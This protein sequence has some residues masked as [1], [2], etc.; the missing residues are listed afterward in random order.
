MLTNARRRAPSWKLGRTLK[1]GKKGRN[2]EGIPTNKRM[3]RDAHD[4]SGYPKGQFDKCG[5]S[6]WMVRM[7]NEGVMAMINIS[8]SLDNRESLWMQEPVFAIGIS[9]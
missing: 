1:E 7:L 5:A 2:L 9:R 4:S 8:W 6:G 3:S